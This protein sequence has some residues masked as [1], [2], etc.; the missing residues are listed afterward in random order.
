MLWHGPLADMP[1]HIG[2]LEID[3]LYGGGENTIEV[4]KLD[5]YMAEMILKEEK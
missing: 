1:Y 3:T 5:R 4:A 2:R